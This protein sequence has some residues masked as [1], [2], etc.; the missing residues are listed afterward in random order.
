VD[1]SST[2]L[3]RTLGPELAGTVIS[4][5]RRAGVGLRYGIGVEALEGH[6]GSVRAVRLADGEVLPAELVVVCLGVTPNDS[7]LRSSGLTLADGLLCD[8][9][10]F[11]EGQGNVVAA[12]DVA[13]W[14]AAL[15]GSEPIRVE[16]WRSSLDQASR[17]AKNLLLGPE[18]AQPYLDIPVFGTHIHGLHFRSIGYPPHAT[19]SE[20]VWGDP[21]GDQYLVVFHRGDTIVGAISLAAEELLASWLPRIHQQ[22]V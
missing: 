19:G 20:V 13:R 5:H 21:G 2:P 4:L 16:H 3:S 14:P 12:G 18:A 8:A 11:A 22:K 15:C 10:L 1:V 7:W 9:S 17:A 6:N